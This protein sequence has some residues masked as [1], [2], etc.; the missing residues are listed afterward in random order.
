[1]LLQFWMKTIVYSSFSA[2]EEVVTLNHCCCGKLRRWVWLARVLLLRENSV[3]YI[4]FRF[5]KLLTMCNPVEYNFYNLWTRDAWTTYVKCV[6]MLKDPMFRL[7]K[8]LQKC[9]HCVRKACQRWRLISENMCYLN[10]VGSC[11]F[12]PVTLSRNFMCDIALLLSVCRSTWWPLL[13]MQKQSKQYLWQW[14]TQC[15]NT[16]TFLTIAGKKL[17]PCHF[18]RS[19]S[20]YISW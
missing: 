10:E 2:V 14:F 13:F 12:I 8:M 16:R 17:S 5:S 18:N 19:K 3:Q 11:R 20:N 4:L 9:Q 15:I 6:A 7:I 1:M